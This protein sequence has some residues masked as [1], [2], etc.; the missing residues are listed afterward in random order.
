MAFSK[1]ED[2][3]LKL[4]EQTDQLDIFFEAINY[5]M[6]RAPSLKTSK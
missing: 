5:M 3:M 6:R 4:V 1:I 2:S